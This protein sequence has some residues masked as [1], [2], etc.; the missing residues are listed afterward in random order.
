MD[1]TQVKLLKSPSLSTHFIC[2]L[3]LFKKLPPKSKNDDE[4]EYDSNHEE[5]YNEKYIKESSDV[6]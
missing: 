1:T 3:H 4:N 5:H 2:V 6:V